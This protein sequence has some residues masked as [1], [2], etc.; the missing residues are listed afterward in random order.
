MTLSMND[1]RARCAKFSETWKDAS[2]EHADAKSFW[3][4]LFEA[5]GANRRQLARFE[6]PV[7]MPGGTTKFIDLLWKKTALVEQKSRGKNLDDARTQGQDYIPYLTPDERPRYLIACDFARFDV[8]DLHTGERYQFTLEKLADNA[9]ALGFL[10]GYQPRR[11]SL[12]APVNIKAV[13]LLGD[14]HDALKEGNYPAHDLERLLVRI[15]FCHFA[16]D[17]GLFDPDAF[18][19]YIINRT[20]EDGS[21]LGSQLQQ[22]FN[23]LDTPLD[24]RQTRLDE[25]LVGL[26]YVNGNVFSG[27]LT[28]AAMD[29]SMRDA[30]LRCV[31]FD[32][33]QVHPGIF[34]SLFQGVM[35][36]KERRAVGAHY[37]SEENI[38]RLLNPLI[39]DELRAEFAAIKNDR[40]SRRLV[41]LEEFHRKLASLQFFD[42]ACGCG[43]F[44]VIAYR[45]MRRLEIEVLKELYGDAQQITDIALLSRVSVTSFHGIEIGEF[46][47][48][49]ARVAMWFMEHIMNTELS[50]AFGRYFVSLPLVH[51]AQILHA[52]SLRTDW[53]QFL[54]PTDNVVVL[55]NPPFIGKQ[56]Q[57]AEQKADI[58][59]VMAGLKG[60]GALDYVTCWYIKAAEYIAGSKARCAFVSTNSITQGEQVCVLWP[61][62]FQRHGI[63]IHFAHRTFAWQ[64]EARGKAHVHVVIIGFGAVDVQTKTLFDYESD[65][66]TAKQ[67]HPRNI[68]PYLVEGGNRTVTK[69]REPVNGGPAIAFGSMPN[70]GGHLLLTPEEK[71]DLLKAQPQ[72]EKWI[73]RLV[74]SEELI[75]GIDRYCLWLVGI[76]PDELRAMP[77]IVARVESVKAKRL[78]SSRPTTRELANTP[79]LF[80]E[81]RQPESDYLAIPEVS[82]ERRRFIPVAWLPSDVIATNKI[83]TMANAT[84]FNFGIISSTMHMAWTRTV[85]GRLESRY[86]YSAGIVYNNFPWPSPDEAQRKAVEAAA[87]AVLDARAAH[88]TAT[89]ADLYDPVTMPPDLAKAHAAL[90]KAVDRCYRPE[91]F[92]S[93]R[94]R[95]EYLFALYEKLTTPLAP[96][97]P[98]K[99]RRTKKAA[100]P[101]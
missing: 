54:T 12:E 99:K 67:T 34:G 50:Y 28:V 100:A 76:S 18:S 71:A 13:E 30:L 93:E 7:K 73:R 8:E 24:Q 66:D 95:V 81:I 37:T 38:L 21:D 45:E 44:L 51:S 31:D 91:P 40:S 49:I 1:I 17:T 58:D 72:A 82:S 85:T 6:H 68:S 89:L 80:G 29:R 20:R 25:A 88:P 52:N 57:D 63:S 32:W 75:N 64:S 59:T 35:D 74:G 60:G 46:A 15:L 36:S 39:M 26:P 70:D 10:G 87:Q 83:Y 42:P 78:T 86:Q 97:T 14:L 53:K 69:T 55:G 90:D 56:Y 98:A 94:E 27:R 3:D 22:F 2:D 41:R 5:Y 9:S 43:N 16:E 61:H 96:A 4:G 19:D 92:M 47:C 48:A 33:S 65:S 101:A 79:T 11:P 77:E 23:V 84:A 62:L